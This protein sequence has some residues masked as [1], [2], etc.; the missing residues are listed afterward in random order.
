MVTQV[1]VYLT[2][3][4]NQRSEDKDIVRRGIVTLGDYPGYAVLSAAVPCSR[5]NPSGNG[6][7]T[8]PAST[9]GKSLNLLSQQ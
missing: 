8:E 6:T 7:S 9:A 2:H 3:T 5:G 4:T 1:S